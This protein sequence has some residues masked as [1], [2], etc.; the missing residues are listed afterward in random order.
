M[1]LTEQERLRS[2]FEANKEQRESGKFAIDGYA[3]NLY[4]SDSEE[5]YLS[6]LVDTGDFHKETECYKKI[7]SIY[8]EI[9]NA[10]N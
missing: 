6:V 9:Q 3:Q 4:G 10:R 1:S 7:S 5:Y 8:E 2:F